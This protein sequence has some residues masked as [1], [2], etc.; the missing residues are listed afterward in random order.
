MRGATTASLA[1]V[2][3]ASFVVSPILIL[4]GEWVVR[5]TG[6]LAPHESFH[7]IA[8]RFLVAFEMT[9]LGLASLAARSC[10]V[11]SASDRVFWARLLLLPCASLCTTL[12]LFGYEEGHP[13]HR[14]N[15]GAKIFAALT[16]ALLVGG[17]VAPER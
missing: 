13:M 6:A 14:K 17:V 2:C 7:P 1:L 5:K 3:A 15:A 16:A 9:A 11:G 4:Q 8:K 12:S 10:V